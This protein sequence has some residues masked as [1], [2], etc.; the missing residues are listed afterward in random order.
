MEVKEVRVETPEG[1]N[2]IIGTAHFIKTVEDL[3]EAMVN[4]VPNIRFGIAF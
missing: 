3:Y 2:V 4:S 1:A